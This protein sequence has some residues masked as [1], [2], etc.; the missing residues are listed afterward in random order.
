MSPTRGDDL[1]RKKCC[2]KNW[3]PDQESNLESPDPESGA[4]PISLSG[5]NNDEL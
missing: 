3:L 5:K 1:P 4:L 2:K